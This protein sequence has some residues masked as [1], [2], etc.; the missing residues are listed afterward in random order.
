M[1]VVKLDVVANLRNL[2]D[3]KCSILFDIVILDL[4]PAFELDQI[5]LSIMMGI[6]AFQTLIDTDADSFF[7]NFSR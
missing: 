3:V 4:F 6:I 7:L 5:R 2:A 1:Q